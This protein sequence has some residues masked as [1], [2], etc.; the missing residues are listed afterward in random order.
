MES[1]NK[2]VDLDLK[3]ALEG[4]SRP[5][6][7]LPSKLFY[8][9]RGSHLFEAIC[10][11]EEYYPTRTELD[12]L[13]ANL[14]EIVEEIHD[15]ALLV[16]P[17]SGSSLK[18]RL[19]LDRLPRLSGYAPIEISATYLAKIVEDLRA[20][21]PDLP[22][23]PVAADFTKPFRL[24]AAAE[25]IDRRVVYFPGSTIGNFADDEASRLLDV[26]ADACG[27][28][29]GMIIG[30]DLE[31]DPDVV[32]RA[33]NDAEGVTAAFNLNILARLNRDYGADFNLGA[34][35]HRAIYLP[36]RGR[37]E[38][39]LVSL[40]DQSASLAGERFRFAEGETVLTEYSNKYTIERFERLA[41]D[42]FGI[43]KVWTDDREWFAVLS[44]STK[45]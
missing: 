18:T 44:L 23:F 30:L 8:D 39:R 26:F 41:A 35:Q 3:E 19:L 5:E 24:P 28:G 11:L 31:K 34:F 2:H 32:R 15:D 9:K 20:A 14:D 36:E 7:R 33:Y 16:E 21:Y 4:L 43:E 40:A 12:I 1:T 42:S 38:M 22:L 27:E 45:R 17:G 25:R 13:E 37:V 10:E 6:K 29:G